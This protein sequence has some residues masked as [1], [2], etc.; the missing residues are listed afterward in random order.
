MGMTFFPDFFIIGAP[1]CGTT[2]LSKALSTHPKICFSIPKEPHYFSTVSQENGLSDVQKQYLDRFFPPR[3]AGCEAIGEGSVSY[4][5][6]PHAVDS[7]LKLN[8][9]AKFIA[10][11]RNPVQMISSFHYRMLFTMDED[12]EDF[13]RAWALQEKR[14]RGEDIPRRCREPLLLQYAEVGK[15]A[16]QIE[17]FFQ[18]VDPKNRMVI[19]F[20][21]FIADL[22]AA[23][24]KTLAFINVTDDDRQSFPKKMVSKTYRFSWLQRWLYRPPKPVMNIIETAKK[25]QE[26]AGEK[27]EPRAISLRKRLIRFNVTKKK[28]V[29]IDDRMRELLRQTFAS[30]IEQLGKLI[31]RDLSHWR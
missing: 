18:K 16:S 31:G 20:D 14:A 30:D 6:S 13:S 25:K 1:R 19:V 3:Q 28:P 9:D 5:Y 7:I 29:P 21:D 10:M 24:K 2:S 26:K 12:V 17:R 4:L 8:P 22:A 15:L 23:Y 11:L 27:T